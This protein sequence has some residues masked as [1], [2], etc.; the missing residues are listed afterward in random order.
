[1]TELSS[2][3]ITDAVMIDMARW[4]STLCA[5]TN[6]GTIECR[7]SNSYGLSSPSLGI[8]NITQLDML[9][10]HACAHNG[11][12]VEC[13]GNNNSFQS[14]IPD[15]LGV[16]TELAVGGQHTCLLQTDYQVRCWG[17]NDWGQTDVPENL[18]KVVSIDAGY[19]HTC[20]TNDIGQVTCWGDNRQG[21]LDVPDDLAPA[22][23]IRSGSFNNCATTIKGYNICWGD[24]RYGQSSI[25][26]DLKD[27]AVGDDHVCGINDEEVFCFWNGNN[28]P[29]VLDIPSDIVSPK[30]IGAGRYHTCV[31]AESGFHC[32]G[33]DSK[34]LDYPAG[35]TNV[36][37][38]DGAI[39]QTC[40]I[41]EGKVTCWG[42][43]YDSLVLG[44]P[45]N[46][47]NPTHIATGVGHSCMID[48]DD[49][50]CW[51]NNRRGQSS[52]RSN[53]NNPSAIAVGGT[54]ANTSET[55]HSCVADDN[56][57]K[58]WGSS[59]NGVLNAPQG[60]SNVIDLHAGTSVSCALQSNGHITCWGDI[61]G[62]RMNK[63]LNIGSVTAMKGFGNNACVKNAR[64]LKCSDYRGALLLD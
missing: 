45:K 63:S 22:A 39:Y 62:P 33:R 44:V 25:W 12:D 32:W 38:I 50:K 47:T 13:W 9:D 51:G 21:Q 7:G 60:L 37:A 24:N 34:N 19:F 15:N 4:P 26:Y 1:M 35:L 30:T 53:L 59:T 41:N 42:T 5:V 14:D 20:A 46:L 16:P 11:T 23:I 18:G 49:V 6:S 36:S 43:N 10:Y 31:W 58:C 56:G 52:S 57:V 2:N 48:D 40:A 61:F 28:S 8:T 17:N 54:Y 3:P 55:G 64:L 29:E 27:F